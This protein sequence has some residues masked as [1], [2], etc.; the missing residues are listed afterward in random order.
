MMLQNKKPFKTATVRR[1]QH[2]KE[3]A[4]TPKNHSSNRHSP[5]L[6][7]RK[8]SVLDSRLASHRTRII[9]S[10]TEILILGTFQIISPKTFC[11][12]LHLLQ[13]LYLNLNEALK[14]G[15]IKNFHFVRERHQNSS[16]QVCED[17]FIFTNYYLQLAQYYSNFN[18][19]RFI[20]LSPFP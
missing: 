18:Y 4:P 16:S 15:K 2:Q 10:G 9:Q 14:Y 19:N 3:P 1:D 8:G 20:K 13:S 7:E 6:R 12:I 17:G 11:T 5:Y